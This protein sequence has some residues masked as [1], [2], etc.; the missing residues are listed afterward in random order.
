MVE[1]KLTKGEIRMIEAG[2]LALMQN[3]NKAAALLPIGT[4]FSKNI[5]N[6]LDAYNEKI[7]TLY[8]AIVLHDEE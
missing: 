5:K 7:N 2:L 4:T 6:D 3:N 8:Q 1:I